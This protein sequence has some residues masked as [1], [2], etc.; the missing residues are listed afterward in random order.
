MKLSRHSWPRALR[1]GEGGGG[2]F[3]WHGLIPL[4]FSEWSPL[5][6][7]EW[8]LGQ[9]K[10][11]LPELHCSHPRGT[12]NHWMVW[13]WKLYESYAVTSTVTR[14]QTSIT[15]QMVSVL[16]AVNSEVYLLEELFF[17]LTIKSQRAAESVPRRIESLLVSNLTKMIYLG[18]IF[19][20]S[21]EIEERNIF[22]DRCGQISR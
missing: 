10:R 21:T 9:G 8:V 12:R 17:I 19:H 6:C 18:L 7:G 20:F 13:V 2:T 14:S 22:V 3:C 1:W 4:G 5:S 16:D 11:S 15:W